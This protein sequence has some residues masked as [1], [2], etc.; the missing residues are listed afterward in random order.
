MKGMCRVGKYDDLVLTIPK[1]F[2]QWYGMV[3]PRGFL[4]GTQMM[5]KANLTIDFTVLTKPQP[6]DVPHF[7]PIDE[8]ILFVGAD[9]NNF[10]NF[11]AEL[12]FWIG[13]DPEKMEMVPITQ[14]SIIRVPAGVYHAPTYFKH[15]LNPLCGSA[16]YLGGD[17]RAIHRR[18]NEAGIEEYIFTG[19][20]VRTCEKDNSKKC[21]FCGR[22][23]AE[24]MQLL[25]SDE[26]GKPSK[27]MNDYLRPYYEMAKQNRTGRFDKYIYPFKPEYHNNPNFLSPRAGFSGA[28][29]IEDAKVCFMYDIIQR[30]CT[31][32]DLHMHHG[33][34]EYLFFTGSDINNFFDFDAEVEIQIGRDPDHTETYTITEPTVIQVP[35]NM[36]HGPVTFKRIGA[37]INYMPIYFSGSYGKVV[38]ERGPN[39]KT[40][41]VFKGGGRPE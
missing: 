33:V 24:K 6:M 23:V 19:E 13:D 34:E 26:D 36:W 41:D 7:H 18:K 2:S 11:D 9:L 30:E 5:P 31:V 20:G 32:G 4:R 37:P 10:F 14:S 40:I 15:F 28:E 16:L 17:F 21:T 12:H 3:T 22:C 27:A 38:R 25:K 39:G 8:Y 29:E 35:S 1:E